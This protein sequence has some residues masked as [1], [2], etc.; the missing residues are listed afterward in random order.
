MKHLFGSQTGEDRS[1]LNV[2]TAVMALI[3]FIA[4]FGAGLAFHYMR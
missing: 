1:V 4:V 3:V 2:P